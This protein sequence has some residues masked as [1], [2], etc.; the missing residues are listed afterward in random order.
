MIPRTVSLTELFLS[1]ET[2]QIF[3]IKIILNRFVFVLD[4]WNSFLGTVN[5]I[6]L[7]DRC[8]YE[9]LE[10]RFRRAGGEHRETR[11][12]MQGVLGPSQAHCE[13]RWFHNDEGQVSIIPVELRPRANFRDSL[14]HLPSANFPWR[15]RLRS[16]EWLR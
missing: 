2:G 14:V 9:S 7:S 11:E 3:L 8:R 6:L 15:P 5:A 10:N 1:E 12:R 4:N 13:A 16:P